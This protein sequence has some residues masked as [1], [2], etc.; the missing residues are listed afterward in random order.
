MGRRWTSTVETDRDSLDTPQLHLFCHWFICCLCVFMCV[1]V[2]ESPLCDVILWIHATC[3]FFQTM[4]KQNL[5]STLQ[6]FPSWRPSLSLLP[7]VSLHVSP[8]CLSDHPSGVIA[9]QR[10]LPHKVQNYP[11][12]RI[13]NRDTS[14]LSLSGRLMCSC[15]QTGRFVHWGE[16]PQWEGQAAWWRIPQNS[17]QT[18]WKQL[19]HRNKETD[20][21]KER[22]RRKT[23]SWARRK[24]KHLELLTTAKARCQTWYQ[25]LRRHAHASGAEFAIN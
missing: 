2:R 14:A 15:A 5:E 13:L 7:C 10:L 1:R 21:R 19:R 8:L 11:I 22:K 9:L 16:M 24:N 6:S 18:L 3:F 20:G 25:R 17:K 23:D 12:A 4:N